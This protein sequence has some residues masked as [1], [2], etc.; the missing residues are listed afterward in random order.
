MLSSGNF[1]VSV[2][3]VPEDERMPVLITT[4]SNLVSTVIWIKWN[5]FYIKKESI[6]SKKRKIR[7]R[8]GVWELLVVPGQLFKRGAESLTGHVVKAVDAQVICSA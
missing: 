6:I 3:T 1:E 4:N 5:L 8:R 2:L 7:G